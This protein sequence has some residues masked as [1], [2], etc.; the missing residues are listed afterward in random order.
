MLSNIFK[1]CIKLLLIVLIPKTCITWGLSTLWGPCTLCACFAQRARKVPKTRPYR[2]P[3]FILITLCFDHTVFWSPCVLITLYFYHPVLWS[4]CILITLYFDHP[5]FWSPCVLITMCFDHPV[6]WSPC[7]L[8]TL[9]FDHPVF[10]LPCV[11]IT[12][13]FD[14]HVFWS[15]CV[16]ITLYFDHAVLWI[17]HLTFRTSR[18]SFSYCNLRTAYS[19]NSLIIIRECSSTTSACSCLPLL[20]LHFQHWTEGNLLNK[21]PS[22]L[23]LNIRETPPH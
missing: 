5:V 6:F 4:P 2:Q 11:L 10:W 21:Y 3:T 19:H 8:I 20:S 23:A 22:L 18:A 17:K 1:T 7:V 9:C 14:P 15:P 13:C 16:L 12:L